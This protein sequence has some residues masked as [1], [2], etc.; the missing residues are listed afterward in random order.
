MFLLPFCLELKYTS[1]YNYGS[2]FS[3][4][5]LHRIDIYTSSVFKLYLSKE[6][7]YLG[8]D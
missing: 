7:S 1:W 4:E 5:S 2:N 3:V 8:K 6:N